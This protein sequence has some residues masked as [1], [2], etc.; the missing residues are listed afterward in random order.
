MSERARMRLSSVCAHTIY[1]QRRARARA[2][3]AN[4]GQP[5]TT[6]T[7]VRRDEDAEWGGRRISSK[8]RG[9]AEDLGARD[10]RWRAGP[11]LRETLN[12][13]CQFING[14][15]T[16]HKHRTHIVNTS[17][18]LHIYTPRI[19]IYLFLLYIHIFTFVCLHLPACTLAL[20]SS[21]LYTPT[22]SRCFFL[23]CVQSIYIYTFMFHEPPDIYR[24]DDFL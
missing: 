5:T 6:K 7:T 12:R 1:C 10:S 2:A 9:R 22:S 14:H 13:Y 4:G 16:Q 24:G 11:K 19:Y 3:P 21:K 8:R 18:H 20:R 23:L 15:L 17:A